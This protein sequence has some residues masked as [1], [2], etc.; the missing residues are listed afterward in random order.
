MLNILIVD[1][2]E[3]ARNR[4]RRMVDLIPDSEV[5]DEASS[6]FEALEKIRNLKPEANTAFGVYSEQC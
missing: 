5:L 1:D 2:E 4:M 3:P 6:A